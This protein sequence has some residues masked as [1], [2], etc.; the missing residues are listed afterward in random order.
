[1]SSIQILTE[2]IFL[3]IPFLIMWEGGLSHNG[4]LR[5]TKLKIKIWNSKGTQR[6]NIIIELNLWERLIFKKTEERRKQKDKWKKERN[7]SLQKERNK[8]IQVYRKKELKYKLTWLLINS[9]VVRDWSS[10]WKCLLLT[11]MM[12]DSN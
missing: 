11:S 6:T 5:G 4:T 7:T 8:E 10:R 9:W 12:D 1:M 2:I 3:T